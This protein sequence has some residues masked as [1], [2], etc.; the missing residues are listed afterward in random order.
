MTILRSVCIPK[1]TSRQDLH[2]VWNVFS[3]RLTLRTVLF[4]SY[5]YKFTGLSFT[6]LIY[7]VTVHLLYLTSIGVSRSGPGKVRDVTGNAKYAKTTTE[8]RSISLYLRSN[9]TLFIVN[10]LFYKV[11]MH[12]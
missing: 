10:L 11:N 4:F 2:L 5:L 1:C 12:N 8:I 3:N 7:I 9:E 6:L